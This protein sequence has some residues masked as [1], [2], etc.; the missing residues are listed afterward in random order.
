MCVRTL[1]RAGAHTKKSVAN[2]TVPALLSVVPDGVMLG[3]EWVWWVVSKQGNESV[4]YKAAF[5]PNRVLRQKPT[6]PHLWWGLSVLTM[7]AR[8]FWT[9]RSFT[10]RRTLNSA[11]PKEKQLPSSPLLLSF[12]DGLSPCHGVFIISPQLAPSSLKKLCIFFLHATLLDTTDTGLRWYRYVWSLSINV[13]KKCTYWTQSMKRRMCLYP[14]VYLVRSINEHLACWANYLTMTYHVL[15]TGHGAQQWLT[16][17]CMTAKMCG[18]WYDMCYMQLH[19]SVPACPR[20]QGT[21]FKASNPA[22]S[23]RRTW[24]R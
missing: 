21:D 1:R 4:N 7:C 10:L 6:S 8:T 20:Q 13:Q 18:V 2:N 24:K 9:K 12:S 17:L 11:A 3:T 5:R 16:L 23:R 14:S 22:A 19:T 15:L